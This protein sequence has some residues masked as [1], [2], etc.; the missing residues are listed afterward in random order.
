MD[1]LPP[2]IGG[3]STGQL[4]VSVILPALN[5]EQTLPDLIGD[6]LALDIS[7]VIVVDNGSTDRTAEVARQAG[8]RVVPEPQRGYG[9]ACLTGARAAKGNVLVF[10]DADGS[11]LA[12]DVPALLAPLHDGTADLVLGSRPLGRIA[13]GAMPPHQRL[14]NWLATRLLRWLFGLR[15]TDLG[16]FRALK[17]SSLLSLGLVEQT[18]GWP[19]EVMV[20]AAR[21]GW[22]VTEVP[23]SYRPRG[24]GKS[25]VS[26]T[27]AG[28]LKAGYHILRT[29]AIHAFQR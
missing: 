23:V 3:Q 24:G 18:Y 10:M 19:T 17:R 2:R 8:A 13:P 4:S 14:G 29:V 12:D 6:L 9:A 20:K 26:G 27:F 7:E 22:R 15:V 5:E 25:K 1:H 28:S 11:F 21:Q 16:A